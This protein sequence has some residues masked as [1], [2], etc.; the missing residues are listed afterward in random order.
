MDSRRAA[1]FTLIEL[2]V[3]LTLMALITTALS[4]ALRIGLAGTQTVTARAEGL[5]E[6]R[7]A[8]GFIRRQLASAR[9]VLWTR[10]NK[11]RAAFKGGASAVQFIAVLPDRRVGPALHQLAIGLSNNALVLQR[12]IT[13]GDTQEFSVATTVERDVLVAGVAK[14]RFAYYGATA[15]ADAAGWRDD[16]IDQPRLPQLIR[17]SLT[18]TDASGR[19][20]WPD[21]I[22][23]TALSPQPR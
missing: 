8:Q 13:S 9:P 6:L 7:L 14:L 22:V 5:E 10:D 23:A 20:P 17:I 19:A 2:L 12:R 15:G 18:F 11:V 1:G 3:G 4:G 21:L 16:W